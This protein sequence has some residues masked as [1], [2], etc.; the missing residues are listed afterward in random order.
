MNEQERNEGLEEIS[1]L[2]D[3]R[4][5][6]LGKLIHTAIDVQISF[7]IVRAL[8]S[9]SEKTKEKDNYVKDFFDAYENRLAWL[10]EEIDRKEK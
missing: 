8:C 1:K 3:P 6:S 5:Y 2:G 9:W 4:E 10:Y 7:D